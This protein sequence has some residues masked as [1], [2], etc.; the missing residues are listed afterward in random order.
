MRLFR[1]RGDT[2]AELREEL[3]SHL[4]LRAEMNRESGMPPEAARAAA[5]R[6]FGNTTLTHEEAR[7]MHVNQFLETV[8]QDLRYALRGLRRNPAFALSAILALALGIGGATAVFSAVDRILFRALP[9][10][11]P[12][13]L[14][15]LGIMTPLDTSEMLFGAAYLDW[16]RRQ[17]AFERMTSFGGV[18]DCD[19][20]EGAPA[21]LGCATLEW[22]FLPT[23]GVRPLFGRNFTPEE[24]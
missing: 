11:E 16:Q 9:Y 23:L 1:R 2:D 12:D 24:D 7:R 13:R 15:S 3:R 19:L 18:T 6:Q 5:Q 10:S 22:N 14:V 21:S 20:T 8:A 4:E 17:S